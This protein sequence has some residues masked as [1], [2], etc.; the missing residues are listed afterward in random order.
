MCYG[1]L[2]DVQDLKSPNILLTAD[3]NAKVA[4]VVSPSLHSASL[5][6]LSSDVMEDS[7]APWFMGGLLSSPHA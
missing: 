1:V 2:G 4:D 7:M 6:R 5:P 3:G